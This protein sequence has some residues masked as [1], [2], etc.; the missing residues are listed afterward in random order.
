M[1]ITR[2]TFLIGSDG[3]D[4]P[5]L[6]EGPRFEAMPRMSWPRRSSFRAEPDASIRIGRLVAGA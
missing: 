6:A 4:R 3:R 1:G 2:A 5:H